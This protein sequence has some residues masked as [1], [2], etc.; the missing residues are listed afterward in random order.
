MATSSSSSKRYDAPDSPSSVGWTQARRIQLALDLGC[1]LMT[2][3]TGEAVPGDP[4][5]SYR[6]LRRHGLRPVYRRENW[7]PPGA[8]WG[9]AV[10]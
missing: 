8:A 2:S 5:H 10:A 1:G 6:N 4:Q 7:C 9:R 3:E